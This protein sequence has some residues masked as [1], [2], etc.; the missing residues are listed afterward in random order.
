MNE[1]V[2]QEKSQI[3]QIRTSTVLLLY[4]TIE[5]LGVLINLYVFLQTTHDYS[6]IHT[7]K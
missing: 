3:Y 2:T 1:K 7:H 6:N 4:R 5:L